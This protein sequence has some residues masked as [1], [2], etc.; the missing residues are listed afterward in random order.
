MS[1]SRLL[2][3]LTAGAA[4][5]ILLTSCS[6]GSDDA[7]LA[8][9]QAEGSRDVSGNGAVVGESS[10]GTP[11]RSTGTADG[12]SGTDVAAGSSAADAGGAVPSS[13][14]TDEPV[15]SVSREDRPTYTYDDALPPAEEVEEVLCDLDQEYFARLRANALPGG[16]YSADGMQTSTLQLSDQL[17]YWIGLSGQYPEVAADVELARTI[18]ELWES[19]VTLQQQGDAAG[20]MDAVQEAD[21]L[22]E[23]LPEGA[24]GIGGCVK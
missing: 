11:G 10:D 3:R 24:R 7:A 17:A 16:E 15:P 21:E 1:S 6:G 12:A 9:E 18:S 20:A 23:Q 5:V 19:S 4:S 22:I 8:P 14:P 13:P 2:L